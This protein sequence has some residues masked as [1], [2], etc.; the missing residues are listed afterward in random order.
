[1]DD[2]PDPLAVTLR[3]TAAR[4]LL[5]VTVLLVEDSRYASEAMRLLCLRSGARLRRADCLRSAQRHLKTY[6]P[7]VAIIDLGLPDGEGVDLIEELATSVPRLPVILGF[8]GALE[9][10]DAALAAGADGFL[11][12]PLTRLAEFQQTLLA[13]L[14][15]QARPG[16]PRSLP[17]TVV[18]PDG[19]ALQDDLAHV[20][21]LLTDDDD[22]VARAYSAQF[23]QAL[24]VSA[25]DAS[26]AEAARSLSQDGAP[27]SITRVRMILDS[28]MRP[29]QAV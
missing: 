2:A 13:H 16:G 27:A 14:P 7:T 12:K 18:E 4:P 29:R 10:E 17:E 5:G 6:R 19:L 26:L 22:P 8:S 9:G 21:S 24:A 20:R 1:M 25:S 28:R 23:L 15:E 3:P 11:A